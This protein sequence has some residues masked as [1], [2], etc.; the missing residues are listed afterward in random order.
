MRAMFL[1]HAG[2]DHHRQTA[3]PSLLFAALVLSPEDGGSLRS[4]LLLLLFL[5]LDGPQPP[6]PKK[7]TLQP[8]SP[9]KPDTYYSPFLPLFFFPFPPPLFFRSSL[10]LSLSFSP[11]FDPP[12]LL[13]AA[14]VAAGYLGSFESKLAHET[15]FY[16]PPLLFRRKRER[17][18]EKKKE[19]EGGKKGRGREQCQ[20]QAAHVQ[21]RGGGRRPYKGLILG[22]RQRSLK[23]REGR[24]SG[25]GV[26]PPEV[27]IPKRGGG[28][29]R[30]GS[31]R[32][33]LLAE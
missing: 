29:E 24:R 21:G 33:F 15:T 4:V 19:K 23:G 25:A 2:G 27:P 12:S 22:R 17:N 7:S 26:F 5:L 16:S 9:P 13:A 1:F 32:L 10:S 3:V 18:R 31:L 6:R 30:E 11:P 28:G 8:S 14:S 20:G